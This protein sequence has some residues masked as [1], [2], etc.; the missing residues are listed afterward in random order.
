MQMERR[1]EM[2]LLR[3]RGGLIGG[4]LIVMVVVAAVIALGN[5]GVAELGI[6]AG[7]AALSEPELGQAATEEAKPIGADDY[8]ELVAAVGEPPD[9][10]FARMRIPKLGVDAGVSPRYVDGEVMPTPDGPQNIAWYDM[11]DYPGMG[12][13]PGG[14]G[15]A[16]FA[17]HVDFANYVHY[18][19]RDFTGPAI[20]YSLDHLVPGDLIEIDYAGET[21]TYQ[22]AW[23]EQLDAA[24]ADWASIWS[25]A[26]AVD[27][28]TLF[29]CGG[30]FDS[31]S[32][33]YSHRLVVRA[34]RI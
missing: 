20:F 6:S 27:S 13:H 9:A 16:I 15:N 7:Q 4:L 14:G 11:T 8:N 31:D 2:R 33:S 24:G 10:T 12:G 30:A 32:H 22:V 21:L 23:I 3:G 25:S 19:D 28:I 29:T 17:G 1:R 34:E 26:V 18:A 5:R